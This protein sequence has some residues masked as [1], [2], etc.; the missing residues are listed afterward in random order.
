MKKYLIGFILISLVA[1]SC[2]SSK[3]DEAGSL[4]DKKAQLQKLKE[5]QTKITDQITVPRL[6]VCRLVPVSKLLRLQ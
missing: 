5:E 6:L 4:S 3:K 1:S 2:G